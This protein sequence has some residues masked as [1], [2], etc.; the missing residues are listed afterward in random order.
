MKMNQKSWVIALATGLIA[1]IAGGSPAVRAQEVTTTE[2][3]T[4]HSAGTVQEV[5]PGAFVIRGEGWP[6]V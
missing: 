1:G 5:S 6:A 2:T 3:R 4:T